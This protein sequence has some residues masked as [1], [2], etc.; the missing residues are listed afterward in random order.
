MSNIPLVSIIIP[1]YNRAHIIWETIES[2]KNQLFENWELILVDDGSFDNTAEVIEHFL[3]D[4]RIIY[5][6]RPKD[7]LRGGNAARNYGFEIAKGSYVKWLDSDDLLAAH[8]LEKQMKLMEQ[9]NYDVVFSRSRFFSTKDKNGDFTW[10][11]YWSRSFPLSEPFKNYLFGKIRFSTADALWKRNFI[12]DVPFK[13]NLRNSQEWL[14][15]IQQLSKE[16]KYL[17]DEE[18]LVYSRLHGEQMHYNKVLALHYK[19]QILARFYAISHLSAN[20]KL[21]YSAF[22]YLHKNM[23]LNFIAP[24]KKGKFKYLVTNLS[25]LIKSFYIGMNLRSK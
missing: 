20:N 13:E 8:C 12:D 18:V 24:L 22:E 7:R 4:P 6:E 17:I 23:L 10:D 14:M 11:K 16:P 5:V 2:I 1:T 25:L 9:G 3:I 19:H 15:L 21:S